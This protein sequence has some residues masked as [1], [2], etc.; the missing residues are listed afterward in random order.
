VTDRSEI[1]TREFQTLRVVSPTRICHDAWNQ[2][3]VL[4]NPPCFPGVAIVVPVVHC[5]RARR[6]CR[7]LTLSYFEKA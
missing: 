1:L 6:P 3:E 5:S 4:L 7:Y 2:G